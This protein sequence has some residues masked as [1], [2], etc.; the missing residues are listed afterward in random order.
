M[1]PVIGIMEGFYFIA[2]M[3]GMMDE[4]EVSSF[5][6]L[7]AVVSIVVSVLGMVVLLTSGSKIGL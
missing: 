4:R 6:K 1:L 5:T 3:L 2:R 7:M